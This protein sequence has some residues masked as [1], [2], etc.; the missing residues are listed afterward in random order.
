MI[1]FLIGGVLEGYFG[2]LM[3]NYLGFSWLKYCAFAKALSTFQKYFM[4]AFHNYKRKAVTGVSP[5]SC[6]VDLSGAVLALF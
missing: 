5:L 1:V 4:Q 3:V 2:V 6:G